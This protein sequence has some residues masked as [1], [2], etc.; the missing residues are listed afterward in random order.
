MATEIPDSEI[1]AAFELSLSKQ[2]NFFRKLKE[3]GIEALAD[4][5][6]S[7]RPVIAL[8]GRPY[9][10]FTREANMGIPKKF[11]S[12]NFSIIPFDALPFEN[13]DIFDNMYWYYGQQDMKTARLVKNEKNLYITFITNFSCAPKSP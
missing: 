2:E 10:A 3:M 11:T 7:D 4:A 8:L 5:R 13:E 12:R 6:K 1:K 9:N